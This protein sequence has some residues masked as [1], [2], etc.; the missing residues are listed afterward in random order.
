MVS[1]SDLQT[2]HVAAQKVDANPMRLVG[3]LAGL[4]GDEQSAGIPTWAWC[5]VA[6]GG[7]I[8]VGWTLNNQLTP[9]KLRRLFGSR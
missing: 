1:L 5:A 2:L 4:S 8:L 6:L 3:R 9:D 7:G